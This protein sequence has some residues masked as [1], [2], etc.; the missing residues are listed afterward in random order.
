MNKH[1]PVRRRQTEGRKKKKKE[2]QAA[3]GGHPEAW[4]IPADKETKVWNM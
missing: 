2:A 1:L 3:N 4:I